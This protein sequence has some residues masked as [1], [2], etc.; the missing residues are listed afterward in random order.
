MSKID[1]GLRV[2]KKHS[3]VR[4]KTSVCIRQS[5]LSSLI[6]FSILISATGLI[7]IRNYILQPYL[8]RAS[9][10]IASAFPE[11]LLQKALTK[12]L[13]TSV[14]LILVYLRL[15]NSGRRK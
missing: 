6:F 9:W 13:S 12:D 4:G 10:P 8:T 14:K 5:V 2:D 11:T 7:D 15:F 1:F 3:V